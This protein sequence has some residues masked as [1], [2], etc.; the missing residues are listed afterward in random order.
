LAPRVE[1]RRRE[2]RGR[3]AAKEA[4]P[5]APTSGAPER[6]ELALEGVDLDPG[7]LKSAEPVLRE[8]NLSNEGA[9][10]LLPIANKMM[11]GAREQTMQAVIDA[12]D[13]LKKAWLQAYQSDPE[14]GGTRR[15]ETERLAQQGMAAL[16]FK[17]GHPFRQMLTDSGLGNHPDMIRTFRRVGE[18]ANGLRAG[19][20]AAK[21]TDERWY[22][23][24]S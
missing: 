20:S 7:F 12:G 15:I 3:A 11:T 21:D 10:K 13:K 24:K 17:A 22:G 1:V 18:L 4:A 5:E 9:N 8:L 2:G 14:I 23:G 6:Y 16:G 19:P